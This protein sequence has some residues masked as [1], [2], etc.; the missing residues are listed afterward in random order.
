MTFESF[1]DLRKLRCDVPNGTTQ[2][3]ACLTLHMN[4]YKIVNIGK[5]IL[6]NNNFM[7]K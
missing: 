1:I 2:G 4:I 3:W 6:Q 7:L 5:N